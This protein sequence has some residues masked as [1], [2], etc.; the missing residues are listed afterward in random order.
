MVHIRSDAHRSS[1]HRGWNV[2]QWRHDRKLNSW[3]IAF[4]RASESFLAVLRPAVRATPPS[5]RIESI[6]TVINGYRDPM[7]HA[8]NREQVVEG[9]QLFAKAHLLM[10]E[11]RDQ[12]LL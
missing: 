4:R 1:G 8:V 7:I 9:V 11:M 12:G 6:S 5:D 10:Q 2:K 3:R